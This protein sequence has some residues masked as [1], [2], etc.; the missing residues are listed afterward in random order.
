MRLAFPAHAE[1]VGNSKIT[2]LETACLIQQEIFRFDISVSH[3]HR[4]QVSNTVDHL[5][6]A[7]FLAWKVHELCFYR[8][9]QISARA[10]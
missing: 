7:A 3:T 2:N 1:D 9:I 10:L 8:R 5:F 4:V 6:E